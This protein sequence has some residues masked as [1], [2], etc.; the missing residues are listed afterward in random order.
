LWLGLCGSCF[1]Q[2]KREALLVLGEKI[3]SKGWRLVF[4]FGRDRENLGLSVP[5]FNFI[6]FLIKKITYY[7]L[8]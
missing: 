4:I 7:F 5:S 6:F 1:A 8:M 2:V 3:Q